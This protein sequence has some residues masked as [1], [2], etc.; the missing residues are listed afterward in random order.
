VAY[1]A[2]EWIVYGCPR[3]DGLNFNIGFLLGRSSPFRVLYFAITSPRTRVRKEKRD[4]SVIRHGP[5][6]AAMCRGI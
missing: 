2:Y 3:V 5:S 1:V 4:R 6:K